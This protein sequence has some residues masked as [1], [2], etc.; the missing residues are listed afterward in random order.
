MKARADAGFTLLE[1]LL[2][3]AL[4]ALIT[5]TL[6]GGFHIGKRAWET[7]RSHESSNEVEGAA[8]ALSDLLSHA[9]PV[10]LP[11]SDNTAVAAFSGGRN[12]CAFVASSE[13][14]TQRGGLILTEIGLIS[15][16]K[17]VDLAVWTGV[18]RNETQFP[19][20]RED[21]RRTIAL[22]DLALFELSYFGSFEPDHPPEWRSYWPERDTLPLLVSVR[23]IAKRFGTLT[24]ISFVVALQQR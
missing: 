24:D 13:G 11:R 22:S 16:A 20:V 10:I 1:L 5:S 12:G 19:L 23:I 9:M 17:H 8:R 18:F 3:V 15:P 7:G 14:E 4:L 2:S 21:A 6:M